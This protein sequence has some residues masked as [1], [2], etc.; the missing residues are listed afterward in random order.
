[1]CVYIAIIATTLQVMLR[2]VDRA[3]ALKCN[4]HKLESW[5]ARHLEKG[6]AHWRGDP[7]YE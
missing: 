1:M 6:S 4:G 3:P 5:L 7:E 2:Q